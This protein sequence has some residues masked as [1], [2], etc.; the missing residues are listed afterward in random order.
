LKVTKEQW[1]KGVIIKLLEITHR[2]LL[3]CCVQVHD[4]VSGTQ[5]PQRNE[6]LQMVIEAQQDLGWEDLLE[7][8]QYLAEVNLEDLE[9]TLGKRQEH[10]LVAIQAA[11]EASHLQGLSQMELH[12]RGAAV[13][14]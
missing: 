9:H 7:E 12:R 8:D 14:G 4:R 5:A 13:K 2:Q 6:E 10:W 3:Y 1:A 11:R